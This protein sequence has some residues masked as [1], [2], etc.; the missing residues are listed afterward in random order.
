[1]NTVRAEHDLIKFS[2]MKIFDLEA[3]K[4]GYGRLDKGNLRLSFEELGNLNKRIKDKKF[5]QEYYRLCDLV[6]FCYECY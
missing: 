2:I 3:I 5:P 1:M 4:M 6:G